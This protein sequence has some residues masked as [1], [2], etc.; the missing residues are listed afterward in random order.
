MRFLPRNSA[1]GAEIVHELFN[2]G[3]FSEE[4]IVRSN[5]SCYLGRYQQGCCGRLRYEPIA[6]P[7]IT[8]SFMWWRRF[9]FRRSGLRRQWHWPHFV[10]HHNCFVGRG[11]PRQETLT[12]IRSD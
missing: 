9:L 6:H 10:N 12:V 7:D 1:L 3:Y 5:L 4:A 8:S 11:F 2:V